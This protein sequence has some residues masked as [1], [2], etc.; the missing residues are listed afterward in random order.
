M[1]DGASANPTRSIRT[2]AAAGTRFVPSVA[3]SYIVPVVS[4]DQH[5]NRSKIVKP[6][7]QVLIMVSLAALN[8][9]A[10]SGCTPAAKPDIQRLTF[11]G[12]TNSFTRV[13][14][15][16]DSIPNAPADTPFSGYVDF[17]AST[18]DS[19]SSPGLGVY[20]G[21]IR[22]YHL[23]IGD[24]DFDLEMPAGEANLFSTSN[25]AD[26]GN[27]K[28]DLLQP[29]LTGATLKGASGSARR[30]WQSQLNLLSTQLETLDSD[31]LP[32]ALPPLGRFDIDRDIKLAATQPDNSDAW[33]WEG[34]ITE[35]AITPAAK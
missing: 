24:H 33:N 5:H 23:T 25:D 26:G 35:A 13:G 31:A 9:A 21:A 14:H 10:A 27:F 17:D 20:K 2:S 16:Y 29:F 6:R 19:D 22:A 4:A 32:K 15:S 28:R 11:S 18:K 12:V 7:I 8:L 1:A 34:T 30:N 3:S